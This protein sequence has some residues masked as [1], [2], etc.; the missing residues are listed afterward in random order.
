MK[1]AKLVNTIQNYE[2]SI[3]APRLFTFKVQCAPI[4]RGKFCGAWP[5]GIPNAMGIGK[6]FIFLL[7]IS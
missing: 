3:M 2:K 1:L 4:G 6:E 7:I 5:A